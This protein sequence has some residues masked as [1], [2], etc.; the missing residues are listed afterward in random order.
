MNASYCHCANASKPSG[1]SSHKEVRQIIA[2]FRASVSYHRS[3]PGYSPSPL[4]RL[5][6][7]ASQMHL[8]V[9]MVK[10]EGQRFGVPAIKMLGASW[11]MHC[12]MQDD[13]TIPGFCTATDGNHGR[14]VAW[15]ARFLNKPARI[16]VP[17]YTV[18][19]RVHAI[20][21]EN[22]EVER[23]EGNYDE[24]VSAA[25]NYAEKTGFSLVQDMAWEGYERI[26]AFIT[27]G[28]YT[29]L[30]E[31]EEQLKE[32]GELPNLVLLQSGNGTWPSAV[33]HF[34]RHHPLFRKSQIL[35][36]EPIA[37][38]CMLESLK[39]GKVRSTLNSQKTI[40]AG[41]N[42]GTPSTLAFSILSREVNGA[43]AI[44]DLYSEEAMRCYYHPTGKDPRIEAGESGAAGL[45]GLLALLKD[46]E[47][48]KLKSKLGID[49]STRVLLF[50]TEGITD[51]D[52]FQSILS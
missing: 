20:E 42:C 40:M 5:R 8:G 14:S 43:F 35:L 30:A 22:A 6:E 33:C 9:I 17:E 3:M 29:Q 51:P 46:P 16:F 37:S 19:A 31:L 23:I 13:P 34:M 28:Y 47:L 44:P 36:V 49:A 27:A 11:A 24:A 41:L 45:A 4:V 48:R 12:L 1:F 38:D 21:A 7:L 52:R 18:Q 15:S 26:P 2:N 50:N 10:D 39:S 25:K 32:Q